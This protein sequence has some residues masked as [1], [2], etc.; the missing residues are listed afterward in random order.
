MVPSLQLS[1]PV[2]PKFFI[3]TTYHNQPP[4]GG[5]FY[6]ANPVGYLPIL[7]PSTLIGAFLYFITL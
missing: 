4:S 7:I 5:F 2:A 1:I 3:R 6:G